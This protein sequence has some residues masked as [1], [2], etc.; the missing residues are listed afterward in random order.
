[1]ES[2]HGQCLVEIKKIVVGG[3]ETSVTPFATVSTTA[4]CHQAESESERDATIWIASVS[5]HRLQIEKVES[6]D[7]AHLLVT[8]VVVLNVANVITSPVLLV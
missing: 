4:H 2:H 8:I 7:D 3:M 1:M 6:K 5:A